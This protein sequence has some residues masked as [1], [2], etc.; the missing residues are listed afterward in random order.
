MFSS[1]LTL[2]PCH[3]LPLPHEVDICCQASSS[4]V[5]VVAILLGY[6]LYLLSPIKNHHLLYCWLCRSW[7][8]RTIFRQGSLMSPVS[9]VSDPL[10]II[11]FEVCSS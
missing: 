9:S 6:Y 11:F 8:L 4:R 10:Q 7:H 1:Y 5:G 3:H 2:S